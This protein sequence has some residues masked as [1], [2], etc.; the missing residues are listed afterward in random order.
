MAGAAARAACCRLRAVPFLTGPSVTADFPSSLSGDGLRSLFWLWLTV[1]LVSHSAA[2]ALAVGTP[3]PTSHSTVPGM[4][5]VTRSHASQALR[6]GGRLGAV[7]SQHPERSPL[8][9]KGLVGCVGAE[10]GGPPL[11][12]HST[13]A[14]EGLCSLCLAVGGHRPSD[15]TFAAVGGGGCWGGA[16]AR[17]AVAVRGHGARS[18]GPQVTRGTQPGALLGRRGTVDTCHS[19]PRKCLGRPPLSSCARH[20]HFPGGQPVSGRGPCAQ[21]GRDHS[22]SRDRAGLSSQVTALQKESGAGARGWVLQTKGY[23]EPRCPHCDVGT[24]SWPTR[25]CSGVE[26]VL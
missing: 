21:C 18:L 10:V 17:I 12:R 11:V 24:P 15:V 19:P 2:P 14:A 23:E 13:A 25:Q 22:T 9:W 4:P 20:A 8:G 26:V 3:V 6:V 5:A 1:R 16:P 7:H